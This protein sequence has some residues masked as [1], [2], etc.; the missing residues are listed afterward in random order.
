[1]RERYYSIDTFVPEDGLGT[2]RLGG[3]LDIGARE[4]VRDSIADA[5][6]APGLSSLLVDLGG[7][8]FLDS[9]ALAGLI[10]GFLKVRETGMAIRMVNANGLVRRVLEVTGTLEL[11]GAD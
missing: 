11:F 4:D 3:S 5:A 9:E 10:E 6:T 8:T 7:V 1:V 2:L